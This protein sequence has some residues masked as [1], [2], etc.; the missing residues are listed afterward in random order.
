MW[1]GAGEKGTLFRPQ[2]IKG[3]ETSNAGNGANGAGKMCDKREYVRHRLR[4]SGYR[5]TGVTYNQLARK[6]KLI[7]RNED[8]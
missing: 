7:N 5:V 1:A 8:G 2:E 3:R 6:R 4:L